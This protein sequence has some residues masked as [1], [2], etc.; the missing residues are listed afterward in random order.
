[1][2]RIR[3]NHVYTYAFEKIG[4]GLKVKF[5]GGERHLKIEL[6]VTNFGYSD[7]DDNVM[8]VT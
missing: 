7:V 8:L 1:M 5:N 3:K 2:N 6:R 4:K